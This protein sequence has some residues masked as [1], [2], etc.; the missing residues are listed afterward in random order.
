MTNSPSCEF[1][2]TDFDS[3]EDFLAFFTSKIWV[4]FFISYS[5]LVLP[6]PQI[7]S[8]VEFFFNRGKTNI[9]YWLVTCSGQFSSVSWPFGSSGRQEG[10]FSRDCPPVFF[11]A[12]GSCELF[13]CGQ[14]CP[15]FDV[16][17]LAFPLPTRV[18]PTLQVTYTLVVLVGRGFWQV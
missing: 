13:W 3:D 4:A 5:P 2:R 14:R 7:P 9:L 10:W 1:S 6:P 15:L 16:V 17:Y 18:L 12:G 8:L 11:F